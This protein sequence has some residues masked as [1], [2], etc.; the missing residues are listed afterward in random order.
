MRILAFET[1]AG[2]VSAAVTENGRVLASGYQDTGLTHS[3]TLMPL[4]EH[5]FRN[6]SIAPASLDAVAVSAGPGSFTGIRIGVAAAK[7]LALGLDIPCIAV[8]TLA[9]LALHAAP[10]GGL[11]VCAM[12]AR[13]RQVY[14]AL[15][16]ASGAS[17]ISG[18]SSTSDI[19]GAAGTSGLSNASGGVDSF[20]LRLTEDRAVSLEDLA[21]ELA[22]DTRPK[23]AAGDGA[24]LCRDFLLEQGI[25]C[26]LAP[27]QLVRQNAIAVALEGERLA[28]AGKLIHPRDLRPFYLRPPYALTLQQR[29]AGQREAG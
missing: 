6:A 10:C 2:A 15:F 5:L 25:P 9:A 7:G 4:A 24:E 17:G 16:D 26:R 19:S 8:S 13:R 22:A 11:L 12:D 20:P 21:A 14:N 27:P 18:I 1:S 28:A 29:Q 23:T 3:R